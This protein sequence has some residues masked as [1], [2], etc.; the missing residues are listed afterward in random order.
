M[1]LS[2]L[3][4]IAKIYMELLKK[5]AEKR[6]PSKAAHTQ[7]LIRWILDFVIAGYCFKTIMY[8]KPTQI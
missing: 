8:I 1:D 7:H 3:A 6:K 4:K 5:N 2:L